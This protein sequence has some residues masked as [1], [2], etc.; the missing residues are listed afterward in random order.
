[1]DLLLTHGYFLHEDEA[2]KRIM[3]PYPTLGILS[4]SAYLKAHALSAQVFDT[5]FKRKS[6]FQTFINTNR[7]TIVGIYSNL[8]TKMNVLEQIQYCKAQ[9][10]KVVVGGPDVPEYAEA[11]IQYGAD[12][13]VIGEGEETMR[14]L[15]PAL[16][17]G[18]SL[19]SIAGIVYRRDDGNI[20]RTSPRPLI[21]DLDSIPLPDREAIDMDTY[22]STWRIHH[23]M[24]SVSLICARGCP[25]TCTWCS[26][27]IYG[28]THRRRSAKNVVD[29][30]EYLL[31][32]YTPDMLWFA[33]DVFTI[34][35][36]WFHDFYD[37]MKRRNIRIP[38]ECISRADRLN[39]EI[40]QK[41][42]E[43]GAFRIWYG[44]ESGSQR[45]LDAMQ[46][47]VTVEEIQSTTTVAQ[48]YGIQIGLFVMLGYPGEH[49]SDI[50]ETTD[51]L[52]Q[53]NA[54]TFLTTVAYP[55]KGTE[56]Y[57]EV[58]GRISEPA[59]W[60]SGTDRNLQFSGRYSDRFYWFAN[61]YL[62]NEVKQH[63]LRQNGHKDFMKIA[64][65]FAKAKLARLGME[66]TKTQRS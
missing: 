6:D 23:G 9:R 2:E 20:I 8:M 66:L 5:T 47:K 43:L 4:I 14:E 22:V 42:S 3:K 50:D 56:F 46:R 54:D 62:V 63:K 1:M 35:H 21:Q 44:S 15:V 45:I 59:A 11:Y 38:F 13:A 41:M 29:E 27:S 7:P 19:G 24:G 28:E 16:Y 61:R 26:R 32:R 18:S 55:I 57:K 31:Q 33:D 12:V 60:A 64:S 39:E 49:L 37:E 51:H 30:I 36:R 65:S 40:L 58:S 25:F 48:K 17:T 52:K 34:H 10:C 53:T